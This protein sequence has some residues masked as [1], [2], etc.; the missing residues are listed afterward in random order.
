MFVNVKETIYQFNLVNVGQIT[1]S[2]FHCK[3]I[4][5]IIIRGFPEK[6]VA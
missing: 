2:L 4:A 3:F 5:H 1:E 6:R